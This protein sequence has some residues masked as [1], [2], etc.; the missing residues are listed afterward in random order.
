[1]RIVTVLAGLGYVTAYAIPDYYYSLCSKI[2]G[3]NAAVIE[4][5]QNASSECYCGVDWWIETMYD[6]IRTASEASGRAN[7]A[8][9]WSWKQMCATCDKSEDGSLVQY[10]QLPTTIKINRTF[11]EANKTAAAGAFHIPLEMMEDTNVIKAGI[12]HHETYYVSYYYSMGTLGYFFGVVLL[13]MCFF[14]IS[15]IAPSMSATLFNIR[16]ARLFRKYIALPALFNDRAAEPLRVT[17]WVIPRRLISFVIFGYWVIVLVFL[18]VKYRVELSPYG[19]STQAA[20]VANALSART[21]YLA[22]YLLPIVFVTAGRNNLL[23]YLTGWSFE[24][25]NH[26]HRYLARLVVLLIIVHAISHCINVEVVFRSNLSDPWTTINVWAPGAMA[27]IFMG[28]MVIQAAKFFREKAYDFF[29]AFHILMAIGFA[30]SVW[31]H[32]TRVG[33]CQEQI[34]AVIALWAFDRVARVVRILVSGPKSCGA[35][36]I[37]D[38][39]VEMTVHY[40]GLWRPHPG[41]HVFIHFLDPLY[42]WQAHPFTV[43]EP[44]EADISDKTLKIF[45]Q[46]QSG[47]TRHILSHDKREWRVWI[48]GPYGIEFDTRPYKEVVLIGGGIG[49]TACQT[50]A[51]HIVK[52]GRDQVLSVHWVIRDEYPLVWF[53]KQLERFCIDHPNISVT[54]YVT[55]GLE[56]SNMGLAIKNQ[57][58]ITEATENGRDLVLDKRD[59]RP[60]IASIIRKHI[61]HAQGP[62]AFFVCGPGRMAD[63]ARHTVVSEMQDTDK[64]VQFFDETFTM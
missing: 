38:G 32:V 30:A 28:I 63:E 26:F 53:R 6:C 29:L 3:T 17:R 25:F 40:S 11:A 52:K 23:I 14:W 48:D 13:R 45:T 35:I 37:H 22:T 60:S 15:L 54:I 9:T 18:S 51:N 61:T 31:Q 34:Y 20:F 8:G 43:M 39:I 57:V 4:V 59:G 33:E 42:F 47:I 19:D 46:A 44:E 10:K 5:C 41:Q 27:L 49:I 12:A 56:K 64:Y 24:D 55:S 16:V 50:Y 2:A 58:Q 36:T 21:G 7:R 1:M 62:L